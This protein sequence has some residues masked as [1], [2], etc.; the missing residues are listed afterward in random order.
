MTKVWAIAWKDLRST[1]RNVPALAMMLVAPL[2]LAGLLGFAFGGG[3]S[4]DI[5]ATKV[6]LANEDTPP[7]MTAGGA[8]AGGAAAGAE[9]PPPASDAFVGILTSES[10]NDVL[11]VTK[12]KDAAAARA[13]VDG[14]DAAVAVVVP[15]DFTAALYG[16]G[17]ARSAVELYVNPTQ[18]FGTA[19]TESIVG[20]ALLD[21]NGARAAAAVAAAT[22][23]PN[24]G[25]AAA[26]AAAAAFVQGGGAGEALTFTSRAPR[27]TGGE[28][29]D[30]PMVGLVLAG[31]MVFFM[32]FGA[33]EVATTILTEA[34]DGTLPRMLTTPTSAATILSGKF[35]SVFL[36]VI[37]QLVVLLAAGVALFGVDW[38]RPVVVA[39]L[40]V[41]TAVVATGLALMIMGVVKTPG[42]AGAIGSGVYVVLALLGGNFTGTV[43]PSSAYA[44][45]QGLTPNG[46]L[47]RA[48][49]A[50]M[51]GGSL[52]EI[53]SYL[54]VPLAFATVFFVVAGRRLGR[55]YA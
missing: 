51:R 24:A 1:A 47:L 42:Q 28:S 55:R 5:A 27:T 34:Q 12:V 8:A 23:G 25:S 46:P 10:L 37:A 41:A 35:M 7:A 11:D 32:F 39:V 2:V 20:Q 3:D 16:S 43:T 49:D 52:G 22:A 45:V 15:R 4:F 48:W 44:T 6:A 18:Q 50:A 26:Q 33:S 17:D 13:R 38:G 29:D 21:F 31:M 40:S 14:G 53:A 54:L 30:V 36:T 9:A 19:I